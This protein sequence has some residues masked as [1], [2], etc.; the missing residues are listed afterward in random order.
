MANFQYKIKMHK[1]KAI[2]Q[3]WPKP[4]MHLLQ[5]RTKSIWTESKNNISLI[6]Y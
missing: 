2:W 4:T 1:W 3:E 6:E 5:E